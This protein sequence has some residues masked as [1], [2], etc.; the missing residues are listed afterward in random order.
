MNL[1][2]NI[3]KRKTPKNLR[4][5]VLIFAIFC[6]ISQQKNASYPENGYHLLSE[7]FSSESFLFNT[8]RQ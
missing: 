6:H 2:K 8:L 4:K 1:T 7:I 3:K 5:I